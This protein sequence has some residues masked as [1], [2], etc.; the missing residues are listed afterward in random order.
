VIERHVLRFALAGILLAGCYG[1]PA[2]SGTAVNEEPSGAAA[3]SST[4]PGDAPTLDPEPTTG[5]TAPEPTIAPDPTPTPRPQPSV[6]L[7]INGADGDPPRLAFESGKTVDMTLSLVTKDL[8][9]SDCTIKHRFDP[10][11]PGVAGASGTMSPL[12]EQTVSLRDGW[13][14]FTA[15]CPSIDGELTAKMDALA[16]DG[17]PERCAGFDFSGGDLTASSV[18]DLQAGMTGTWSGCV[19]TPWVP[20]YWVDFTFRPDGSYSAVASEV[21]D[22]WRTNALYYG[23]DADSPDKQVRILDIADGVGDGEIDV[24]FETSVNTDDL[25]EIKLMGDALS[26]KMIHLN[27]YGP[28]VFRLVRT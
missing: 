12:A 22:D 13:H 1:T 19:T 4:L 7:L 28:L 27:E 20:V 8:R 26:F 15:R 9:R 5:P 23:T 6:N 18:E 25:R 10:D 21:L 17:L 16:A 2:S 3:A 14:H 24:V 11:A